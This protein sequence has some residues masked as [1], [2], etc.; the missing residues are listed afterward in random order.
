M[1]IHLGSF[2]E[3]ARKTE[4]GISAAIMKSLGYDGYASNGTSLM[5]IFGAPGNSAMSSS[6]GRDIEQIRGWNHTAI[7]AKSLQFGLGNLGVFCPLATAEAVSYHF[8]EEYH[9]A[10]RFTGT[11]QYG[12]PEDWV[13]SPRQHRISKLLRRPNPW[14]DRAQML[15]QMSQQVEAHGVCYFLVLPNQDGLPSQLWVIPKASVIPLAPTIKFPEGSFRIGNL[16]RVSIGRRGNRDPQSLQEALAWISNQEY[17][18]K[19]VITVGL[20]SIV[21]SDDFMNPSSA[22]A[23][24][25]DTDTQ[26]HV[27]RRNTLSKQ[28]TNGPRIEPLPGT[29]FQAAE[30][31]K[32]LDEF[33][34]E[35]QGAQNSGR[36]WMAPKGVK[37]VDDSHSAREMEFTDSANQSRDHVLGQR[38]WPAAMLGLGDGGSYS[39]IVGLIK[40]TSRLVLQPLMRII[41]GQLT[42]GLQ[43]FFEEPQDEFLV[44]IQAA[45]IDDPEQKSKE[46]DL[47]IRGGSLMKGELRKGFNMAPFD[48]ER[49]EEIA[50]EPKAPEGGMPGA[51]G[52]PGLPSPAAGLQEPATGS[53]GGDVGPDKPGEQS[54]LPE[55][56]AST[57]KAI[58]NVFGGLK[59][60]QLLNNQ[61]AV[62]DTLV[63]LEAKT[64]REKTAIAMLKTLGLSADQAKEFVDSVKDD[65]SEIVPTQ[66]ELKSEPVAVA[67]PEANALFSRMMT[68]VTVSVASVQPQRLTTK[69]AK[70]VHR[71]SVANIKGVVARLNAEYL[72]QQ[73]RVKKPVGM[74]TKSLDK[75]DCGA[76]TDGGHGFQP[77]NT[78]G[79]EDGV[80]GSDS[81]S[82]TPQSK[83]I[84]ETDSVHLP[85]IA[86]EDQK[87]KENPLEY[88]SHSSQ[89]WKDA[90]AKLKD[91]PG[92]EGASFQMK[93]SPD[94]KSLISGQDGQWIEITDKMRK[95]QEESGYPLPLPDDYVAPEKQKAAES[96]IKPRSIDGVI[97]SKA[98]KEWRSVR[99]EMQPL[100]DREAE[101]IDGTG[102]PLTDAETLQLKS[103]REKEATILQ[104]M[105]D[106]GHFPYFKADEAVKAFRENNV[107]FLERISSEWNTQ[108]NDYDPDSIAEA[109]LDEAISQGDHNLTDESD[110]SETKAEYV[111]QLKT[112][113]EKNGIS[114]DDQHTIESLFNSSYRDTIENR[115]AILAGDTDA[116]ILTADLESDKRKFDHMKSRGHWQELNVNG[117]PNPNL[118]AV[119]HAMMEERSKR[120]VSAIVYKMNSRLDGNKD[121]EAGEIVGNLSLGTDK[122]LMATMFAVNGHD[123]VK[124]ATTIMEELKATP[125]QYAEPINDEK[126]EKIRSYLVEHFAAQDPRY[127]E[128]RQED[129]NEHYDKKIAEVDELF[130][131]RDRIKTAAQNTKTYSGMTMAEGAKYLSDEFYNKIENDVESTPEFEAWKSA[132]YDSLLE[133]AKNNAP[134]SSETGDPYEGKFGCASDVA[135]Q[136]KQHVVDSVTSHLKLDTLAYQLAT[137]KLWG[138]PYS[139]ENVVQRF[140]DEWAASSSDHNRTSLLL[141]EAV[142]SRFGEAFG[143]T[144]EQQ[145]STALDWAK[146]VI[147]DPEVSAMMQDVVD[148]IYDNTQKQLRESHYTLFRG[149]AWMSDKL[150]PEVK[151]ALDVGNVSPDI[152]VNEGDD[153]RTAMLRQN[154]QFNSL[155]SFSTDYETA[156]HFSQSANGDVSAMLGAI[157]PKNRIFATFA[158]GVGCS[159][160]SEFVVLGGDPL[161]SRLTVGA[162]RAYARQ[163]WLNDVRKAEKTTFSDESDQLDK[164]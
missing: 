156:H 71:T 130:A 155:A 35:N 77:G 44:I 2:I 31:D 47:L 78:C 76:N 64:I 26:I 145:S 74:T 81:S 92:Y 85:D 6:A 52:L 30:R 75:S 33:E 149:A 143:M 129:I 148:G 159:N 121:A 55:D 69:A 49:D 79:K 137:E 117:E 97:D 46:W 18:A 99:E 96:L 128:M 25:L 161:A 7:L 103:F 113:A 139:K 135:G 36:A 160:E 114:E 54:A 136:I 110:F 94:K 150:P 5:D 65:E 67:P 154:L 16:S 1:D 63:K 41:G 133:D 90:Y 68:P 124:M 123:P 72:A 48:D 29:D 109:A 80:G 40:G 93:L 134:E 50:G 13:E 118:R 3:N 4:R 34:A 102:E 142:K 10:S 32:L 158:T 115:T 101:A 157:V 83:P 153:G 86:T 28:M 105:D 53:R 112:L 108:Q 141:Q 152:N 119:E 162:T 73:E 127:S 14:C 43:R 126:M 20:P 91:A 66:T 146:D 17:S 131:L 104:S 163:T 9:S 100:K 98:R 84:H 27:S 21:Y 132:K 11:E 140:L 82:S 60:K 151:Q 88:A 62:M 122:N 37:V 120:V 106:E 22:I 8:G 87:G 45:S 19:Y 51:P 147:K 58:Q 42:I 38:L 111:D 164:E 56:S 116:V 57:D 23:D 61:K 95:E 12:V 89:E 70:P 24:A 138:G 125:P 39:Q 59:R 107:A 144:R 15:F